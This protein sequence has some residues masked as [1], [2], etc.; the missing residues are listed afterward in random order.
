MVVQR[1]SAC[2]GVERVSGAR[3]LSMKDG[4]HMGLAPRPYSATAKVVWDSHLLKTPMLT[5]SAPLSARAILPS[6][7]SILP[8]VFFVCSLLC[9]TPN[10]LEETFAQRL[11]RSFRFVRQFTTGDWPDELAHKPE[12]SG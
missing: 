8:I 7:A 1:L 5:P 2:V 10:S 4:E 6:Q 3:Y 11:P 9:I 12:G